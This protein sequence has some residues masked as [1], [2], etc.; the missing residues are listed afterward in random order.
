MNHKLTVFKQT[1][2]GLTIRLHVSPGA[3]CTE[4]KG[5]FEDETL[6]G[7]PTLFQEYTLK[8]SIKEAPEKGK[9]NAALLKYLACL[10]NIPKSELTLLKGDCRQIKLLLI[11]KPDQATLQAL[12]IWAQG[13]L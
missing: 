9:A 5:I 4:I 6:L 1:K 12:E 7:S 3:R 8:I 13:F 2:Q 11:K 10:W